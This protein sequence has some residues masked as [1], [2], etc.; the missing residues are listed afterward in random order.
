M[1]ELLITWAF[2]LIALA[3]TLIDFPFD[4][5]LLQ[6]MVI[7]SICMWQRESYKNK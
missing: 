4:K 2:I 5:N 7:I 6:V 1:K 3:F